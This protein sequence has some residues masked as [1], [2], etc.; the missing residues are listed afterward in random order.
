MGSVAEY[1]TTMAASDRAALERI[2][3]IA[4]EQVPEAVEGKSYGMPALLYRDKGLIAAMRTRRFLSLYPFSGA[5]VAEL[6]EALTGFET[7]SG[8]VHFSADSPVPDELVRR[9]VDSRRTE[10]EARTSR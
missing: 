1:L 4:R 7:T 2:Y 6:A 3:A 10:I 9:I 5:V 8:S